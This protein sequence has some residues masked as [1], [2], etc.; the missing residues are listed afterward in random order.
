MAEL[1]RKLERRTSCNVAP[2]MLN[3]GSQ[4]IFRAQKTKKKGLKSISTSSH[5]WEES[6]LNSWGIQQRP[7]KGPALVEAQANSE[8]GL[9]SI[10]SSPQQKWM[11]RNYT[12]CS[13]H[14]KKVPWS[15][16]SGSSKIYKHIDGWNRIQSRNRLTQ[17]FKGNPMEKE[18]SFQQ[19]IKK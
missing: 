6:L 2:R 18:W 3:L 15:T 1:F 10:Y 4:M 16:K 9:L 7:Q 11:W 5:F 17:R 13:T 8:E 12:L 14:N 19:M